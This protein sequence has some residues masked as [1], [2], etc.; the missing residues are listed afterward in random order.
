MSQPLNV[1][2]TAESGDV[3]H[4]V[5]MGLSGGLDLWLEKEE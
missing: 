1:T 3:F 5:Q 4:L 2:L